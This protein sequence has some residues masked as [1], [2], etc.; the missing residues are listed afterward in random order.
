MRP[1]EPAH[2]IT[3]ANHTGT[4]STIASLTTSQAVMA[5]AAM[6]PMAW[7][8]ASRPKAE[9]RIPAGAMAAC[10]PVSPRRCRRRATV[11]DREIGA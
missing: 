8:V 3:N 4:C 2:A 9:P 5:D 7:T 10:S 11:V 1:T 6:L